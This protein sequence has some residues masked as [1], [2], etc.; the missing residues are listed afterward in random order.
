MEANENLK[1]EKSSL[2]SRAAGS[3]EEDVP[4]LLYS[5]KCDNRIPETAPLTDLNFVI[6]HLNQELKK[7]EAEIEDLD[8]KNFCLKQAIKSDNGDM[9]L[10]LDQQRDMNKKL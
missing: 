4:A 6:V 1:K 10:A 3:H 5:L 9:K 2:R 8:S 7:K